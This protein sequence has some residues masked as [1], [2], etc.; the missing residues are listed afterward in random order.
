MYIT[1]NLEL[2]KFC[3]SI[4]NENF[5][6]IDT[7]FCRDKTYY[8]QL[9]LVQIATKDTAVIIDPLIEELD[10]NILNSI[11]QNSKITKVFHSA[12]QDLEIILIIFNE[13]PKNIFDT[14]IAASFCGMGSSI[15]YESLVGEVL[16]VKID[17]SHCLSD[18]TKRPLSN[19]QISYALG[20]VTYLYTIYPRLLSMLEEQDRVSWAEEEINSLNQVDNFF[21]N[22]D[23]AWSKLRNNHRIKINLVIKRL[24]SWRELQARKFNLPR[25]HYLK[26]QYLFDLARIL[27]IT[28]VELRRIKH[29]EKV[30]E[31]DGEE[32]IS[33]IRDALNEQTEL[34]LSDKGSDEEKINT[35]LLSKL[36]ILL[37]DK[38]EK[39]LLPPSLISTIQYLK[40]FCKLNSSG[41]SLIV[42][43]WRY[44]VFGEEAMRLKQNF[45]S[46]ILEK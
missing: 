46:S 42:T 3:D 33:I 9:C 12:K 32:I 10:L 41:E 11:L 15:S 30:S 26:E 14:Q 7:E 27:P 35:T 38:S 5:I 44:K 21:V 20:D 2:K 13:L 25:N 39:Y 36:K 31:E 19:Q 40:N 23:Q 22:M 16:G 6:S 18:W 37:V 28:M 43:G 24:A 1:T 4:N 8:P 17:K 34:D 45:I 29:F